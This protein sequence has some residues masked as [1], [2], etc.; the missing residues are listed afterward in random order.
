MNHLN[1]LALCVL[2]PVSAKQRH[3][4]ATQRKGVAGHGVATP[5]QSG[6]S[7]SKGKQQNKKRKYD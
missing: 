2:Y 1:Q 7:H 6:A 5:R 3:G 4:A